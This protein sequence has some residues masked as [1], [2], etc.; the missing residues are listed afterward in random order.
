MLKE[1]LQKDRLRGDEQ[2]V[3]YLPFSDMMPE[4]IYRNDILF[5]ALTSLLPPTGRH[6]PPERLNHV[7]ALGLLTHVSGDPEN[8][9]FVPFDHTRFFHT[10]LVARVGEKILRNNGI[11]ESDIKSFIAAA[12]LHDAATPALGDA[13]K[14]VDPKN[15]NE[16]EF[17]PE[18]VN[19]RGW[20]YIVKIGANRDVIGK[21][22]KNQ[23]TLGEILDIAD[24]IAYVLR[25][26]YTFQ[27]EPG[28]S[29]LLSNYPGIGNIYKDVRV[30]HKTGEI[31]SSNPDRLGALLM[32]RA[33][34]TISLYQHP[35]NMGR[36]LKFTTI[37]REFYSPSGAE[38]KLSPQML[39]GMT[40]Q[41]LMEWLENAQGLKPMFPGHSY[42]DLIRYP[43]S[44]EAFDNLDKARER[45]VELERNP[46]VSVLGIKEATGFDPGTK[47]KVK[48]YEGK[49]MEFRD[50]DSDGANI[51]E[52]MA[53]KTRGVFLYFDNK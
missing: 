6:F 23:G 1:A 53:S 24:R 41:E 51:L 5:E 27:T 52:V 19:D 31:Y 33:L 42:F 45:K 39:R 25:D 35:L 2:L 34:L 7:R 40:D 17:W 16:E 30:N 43:P 49:I 29:I 32:L 36:D 4:G 37:L 47:Y 10:L 18:V 44:Y 46:D 22:I 14:A 15:L 50:F 13:T 21:I 11:P 28:M 8:Q 38:G 26:A 12:I 3:I 20:Q 48:D 9:Y